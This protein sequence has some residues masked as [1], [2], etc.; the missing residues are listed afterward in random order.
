MLADRDKLIAFRLLG[1]VWGTG[2]S[3]DLAGWFP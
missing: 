2:Y 3:P 1:Q